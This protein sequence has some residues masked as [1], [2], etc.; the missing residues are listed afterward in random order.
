MAKGARKEVR[1]I[2]AI[3]SLAA[4][5]RLHPFLKPKIEHGISMVIP[6]RRALGE[7]WVRVT[8]G[9]DADNMTYEAQPAEAP[10][11][12]KPIM[13][14]S[15]KDAEIAEYIL[16]AQMEKAKERAVAPQELTHE[17]RCELVNAAWRDYVEQKL[18]A[19]RGQSTFGS[20]GFTQ[21]QRVA[22]NPA[23][24]PMMHKER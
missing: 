7:S 6:G 24:R 2:P 1:L 13:V 5:R 10:A 16:T 8:L 18:R 17:E 14:I 12:G 11:D 4:Q 15:G 23:T 22:Q 20:G 9:H 21:R 19:L 3:Q